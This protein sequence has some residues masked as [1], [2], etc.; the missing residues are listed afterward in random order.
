MEHAVEHSMDEMMPDGWLPEGVA[1]Y[2]YRPVVQPNTLADV[3]AVEALVRALEQ[4]EYLSAGHAD[5]IR[6]AA[7]ALPREG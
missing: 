2:S 4:P 1:P 3:L 5:A 6:S 7:G